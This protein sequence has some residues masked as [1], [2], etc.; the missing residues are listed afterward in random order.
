VLK[1]GAEHTFIIGATL[2][3]VRGD[4]RTTVPLTDEQARS[5]QDKLA[6]D[7]QLPEGSAITFSVGHEMGGR[8]TAAEAG[9]TASEQMGLEPAAPADASGKVADETGATATTSGQGA[10]PQGDSGQGKTGGK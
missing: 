9:A 7:Q 8:P 5:F 4:G 10:P 2:K 1:A 3:T 6:P